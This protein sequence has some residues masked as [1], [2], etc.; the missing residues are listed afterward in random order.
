MKS[1][2]IV[3][4]V[5]QP[6]PVVSANTS[7]DIAK[8]LHEA[9]VDVLVIA[10]Y[11][12]RGVKNRQA[13]TCF[14]FTVKRVLA[15]KSKTSSMISRFFE[16]ITFGLG[17]T[18][19][20][21]FEPK[22]F[23]VAY[24]NAWPTFSTLLIVWALRLRK[25]STVVSVQDLYPESLISQGRIRGTGVVFNI[26]LWLE[27]QIDKGCAHY[28]VICDSF[29]RA[30]IA[31]GVSPKKIEVVPNWFETIDCSEDKEYARKNIE[32]YGVMLK[33][34]FLFTY[35]GN[36]GVAS[37]VKN[38]VEIFST[39][40][41]GKS[42]L[43]AGMG[44]ELGGISKLMQSGKD[45]LSL[46]SPWPKEASN[47]VFSASDVLMLPV[48]PGQEHASMPSKLVSYMSAGKPV[49]LIADEECEAARVVRESGCGIIVTWSEF[50]ESGE[51]YL[52]QFV[53]MTDLVR[54]KM[55]LA[56]KS[57]VLRFFGKDTGLKKVFDVLECIFDKKKID[58]KG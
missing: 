11:P 33:G 2:L 35:A 26:I 51:K 53:T 1:I 45:H 29:K 31:R 41:F 52:D 13:L 28:I 47:A 46:L 10:P 23:E 22:R 25:I 58:L 20:I 6:E 30:L 18:F 9:G 40:N 43:V 24:V 36:L 15:F 5:F 54:S 39:Q 32:K 42:L 55:G 7:A 16:N 17:A 56:G 19:K 38:M 48:A 12:N 50:T 14:P 44:S 34:G 4:C 3:S 57:Y 8:F 49:L 21:L 27:R 37:G